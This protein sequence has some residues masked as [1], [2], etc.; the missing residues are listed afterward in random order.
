MAAPAIKL[1]SPESA[2]IERVRR[3]D[4]QAF[5][6]LVR[7]CER[8]IYMAALSIAGNEADAEEIVQEA[9]L[10]AFKNFF[11]FRQ[12]AKFST[13]LTQITLNEALM[14]VRRNRRHVFESL[15]E[16]PA[17]EGEYSPR[18]FA[19]WREI[20]SQALERKELRAA[21]MRALRSLPPKLNVV[22]V[23]RDL[24]Q[25]S[26]AETARTLNIGEPTVK[27]R[28]LRA[29]LQM[30]D[31]L[32]AELGFPVLARGIRPRCNRKAQNPRRS[33]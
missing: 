4:C 6:E 24:Q 30:R 16:V 26:T 21:L 3:G 31:A 14:R 33:Q 1:C 17:G 2:L 5:Y 10:K 7:P 22:L 25:L 8:S 32:A 19:D 18:E 23:L 20:P 12:E 28:L 9:I 15:D 27:T 11:R 29:R 13:W